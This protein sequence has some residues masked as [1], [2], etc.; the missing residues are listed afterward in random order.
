MD[1]SEL[2]E[3]YS[4]WRQNAGVMWWF[5]MTRSRNGQEFLRADAIGVRVNQGW[6]AQR[7]ASR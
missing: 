5:H 4:D 2:D 3:S 6:N 7:M 1:G